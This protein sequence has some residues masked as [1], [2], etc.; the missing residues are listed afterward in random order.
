MRNRLWVLLP[1]MIIMISG[2]G[3]CA[4]DPPEG[5]VIVLENVFQGQ[6]LMDPEIKA[7][8]DTAAEKVNRLNEEM[9]KTS[10]PLAR[11]KLQKQVEQIKEEA[12]LS[13][14]E[15]LIDL[16]EA[17]GD[18]VEAKKLLE[19]LDKHQSIK[20]NPSALPHDIPTLESQT[21]HPRTPGEK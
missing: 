20:A 1:F 17:R 8:Q 19:I 2:V 6:S 21:N 12:W 4:E 5:R 18:D 3:F 10:D 9:L 7:I 14:M 15:A 11:E 13:E 16:A